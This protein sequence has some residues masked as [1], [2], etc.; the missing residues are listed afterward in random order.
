VWDGVADVRG[1]GRL[2]SVELADGR[3]R[4][5]NFE[6]VQEFEDKRSNIALEMPR[7]AEGAR[8]ELFAP[9]RALTGNEWRWEGGQVD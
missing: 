7:E 1:G 3:T 9:E 4:A 5:D 2:R 6:G 8:Q